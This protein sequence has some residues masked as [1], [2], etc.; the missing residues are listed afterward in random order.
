[1]SAGY[2]LEMRDISQ[3]KITEP[4]QKSSYHKP[5]PKKNE[6][7]YIMGKDTFR[8]SETPQA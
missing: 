1:M 2:R 3:I 8:V 7:F 4:K 5:R 6:N